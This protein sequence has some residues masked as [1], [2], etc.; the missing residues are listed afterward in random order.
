MAR[1]DR[2]RRPGRFLLTGSAHV[3]A[4][5]RVA[6][7]LTGRME[8]VELWP[9]SQGEIRRRRETFVDRLFSPSAE[10]PVGETL[11]KRGVLELAFAGGFPEARARTGSRRAAWFEAYLAAFAAHDV[12]DIQEIEHSRRLRSLLALLAARSTGL[13]NV[14]DLAR[15]ARLASST[16][17]RYVHLLEAA[18]LVLRLPAWSRIRTR[19]VVSSP[20]CYLADSALCAHLLGVDVDSL[21][22]ASGDAGPVLETFA[23]LE[24]RKQ[25]GWSR[26]RAGMFHLRTK[27][28]QE[29][30]CILESPSGDVAGVEVKA[31][32]TVGSS[33][34]AG[35]RWLSE[36]VGPAFRSGVVL[37]AGDRALPFGPRMWALPFSAL[38]A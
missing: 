29:V 34:F 18:Y 17:R 16:A 5:P 3:L 37:H 1:V 36:R 10:W 25:L 14:D 30:D 15:D 38:W 21:A 27:K 24:L 19:R 31:G 22:R 28:L 11:D 8:I 35:L 7:A 4:L 32:A 9:L 26:T 33:D 20:K 12:G 23:L 13:L 2:D 6:D